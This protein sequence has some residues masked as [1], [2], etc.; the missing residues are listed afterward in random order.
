MYS[1]ASAQWLHWAVESG[2]TFQPSCTVLFSLTESIEAQRSRRSF[3]T[4]SAR[5]AFARAHNR[6][7]AFAGYDRPMFLGQSAKARTEARISPPGHWSYR[8]AVANE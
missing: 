3:T 4:T 8:T 1:G 5:P 2:E 7:P 6:H